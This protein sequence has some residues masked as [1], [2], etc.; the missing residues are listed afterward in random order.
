M[1]GDVRGGD[2]GTGARA[3]MPGEILRKDEEPRQNLNF[4]QRDGRYFFVAV[5]L[6]VYGF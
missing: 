4:H 1:E 3:P 5:V 2:S 6:R